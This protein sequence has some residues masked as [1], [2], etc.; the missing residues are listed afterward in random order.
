MRFRGIALLL[1]AAAPSVAG[2]GCGAPTQPPAVASITL[3][4]GAADVVVGAAVAFTAT[5]RDSV[6]D[7][8]RGRQVFWASEDSSI[9]T[10]SDLGVVTGRQPGTTRIAASAEGRSA[11]ARVTVQPADGGGDG[12]RHGGRGHDGDGGDR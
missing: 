1:V 6:G 5:V 7:V 4:P 3:A 8:L 12:G 11:I 9:I 10:V 2:T